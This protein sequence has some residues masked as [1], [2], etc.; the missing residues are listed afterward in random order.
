MRKLSGLEL[1]QH[2]TV[3]VF[4]PEP[5]SPQAD[6]SEP[7]ITR[8]VKGTLMLAHRIGSSRVSSDGSIQLLLSNDDGASWIPRGRPFDLKF[9]GQV[10]DLHAAPI[11]AIEGGTVLSVIGVMDRSNLA[12]LWRNPTTDGRVP[13]KMFSSVSGDRGQTWSS[14]R[15]IELPDCPQAIAYEVKHLSS[16]RVIAAFETFKDYEDAGPWKYQAGSMVSDDGGASWTRAG[17]EPLTADEIMWWDPRFCELADGRLVQFYHAFN[18]REGKDL[19]VHVA[20]SEDQGRTWSHPVSTGIVGQESYPVFL[21]RGVLL[22]AVQCR[23][24][25]RGITVHVSTDAG[26]T[27]DS[28]RS[29]Q[30]Y[31]HEGES[32]GQADGSITAS[33]YFDDMDARTFGHPSGVALSGSAALFCYYTGTRRRAAIHATR[34]SLEPS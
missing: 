3:V 31:K 30:I 20:W 6:L 23:H 11:C 1:R 14:P 18:Y 7:R 10:F 4:S 27:F 28:S 13:L 15:L 21:P 26:L 12:Q 29:V 17:V 19:P 9:P 25:P 32:L 22:L 33:E 2:P 34:V 16:G 5:S 24:E 8:L